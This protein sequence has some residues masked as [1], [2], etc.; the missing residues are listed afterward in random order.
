MAEEIKTPTRR[1]IGIGYKKENI[2][3]GV[4]RPNTPELFAL[5]KAS[6]PY[7]GDRFIIGLIGNNVP[8]EPYGIFY[9]D[10]N[11]YTRYHN[12]VKET[13]K[14]DGSDGK[15]IVDDLVSIWDYY[16][17]EQIYE[18][19]CRDGVSIEY[20]DPGPFLEYMSRSKER[21]L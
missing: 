19:V 3:L 13:Y 1:P 8:S 6:Y 12:G 7:L 18:S 2:Y 15:G 4:I 10:E 5:L 16:K 21:K 9:R 14:R 11:G 20:T 17:E